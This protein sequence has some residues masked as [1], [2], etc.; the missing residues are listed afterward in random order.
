[1][2]AARKDELLKKHSAQKEIVGNLKKKFE[3]DLTG[4][5]GD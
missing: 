3:D 1:L 4:D 5:E 2:E